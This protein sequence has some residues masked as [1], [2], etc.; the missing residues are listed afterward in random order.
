MSWKSRAR[1]RLTFGPLFVWITQRG[2]S[3]W[4]IPWTWNVTRGTHTVDTPGPGHVVR[5]APSR[6]RTRRGWAVARAAGSLL[7]TL[8]A[9][10]FATVTLAPWVP[11]AHPEYTATAIAVSRGYGLATALAMT[12]ALWGIAPFFVRQASQ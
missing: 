7:L 2:F 1:K 9:A 12:T 11:L 3:S 10:V 8:A 6:G 5:R 4:G